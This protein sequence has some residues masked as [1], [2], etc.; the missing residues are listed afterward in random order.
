M[1]REVSVVVAIAVSALLS[2][3][4]SLAGQTTPGRKLISP[5]RGDATVEITKPDTKIVKGEVITTIRVKNVMTAPIAGFQID[6]NWFKGSTNVGGD[7]YRHP[8][9][10]PVGEVIVVTLKTPQARIIGAR[11]QYQFKHANGAIKPKT[12][13]KLDSPKTSN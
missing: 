9:P 12:V 3:G 11:N 10:L 4:V 5:V 1:K 6:E 7:T 13:A 2:A 8:R